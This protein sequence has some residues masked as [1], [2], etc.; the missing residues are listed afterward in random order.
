MLM[1]IVHPFKDIKR[2]YQKISI[3]HPIIFFNIE[4]MQIYNSMFDTIL[5]YHFCF[6]KD[7]SRQKNIFKKKNKI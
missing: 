5:F 2:S 7:P 1:F 3:N 6:Q 4:K